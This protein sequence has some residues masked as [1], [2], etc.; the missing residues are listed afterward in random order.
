MVKIVTLEGS[1]YSGKTSTLIHLAN[2]YSR[3]S[4]NF[5]FNEGYIYPTALT[6]RMLAI[7]NQS[8]N[9]DANF[10]NTALFIQDANEFKSNH[11]DDQRVVFQDRYWPSTIAYGNFLNKDKSIHNHQDYRPLFL[12]LSAT[13][14]LSCS[15]E[16]KLKRSKGRERMSILDKTLLEGPSELVRLEEEIEISIEGQ[17][18]IYRIDTTHKQIDEVA[19]EIMSYVKEIGLLDC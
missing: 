7:R 19:H 4:D 6:A 3:D 16:E 14:V 5:A 18:N 17:S 12:P 9:V 2:N 1:D 8:N 15:Y 10:I 13:I 11:P